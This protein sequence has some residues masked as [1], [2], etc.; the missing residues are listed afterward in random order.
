MLTVI[1]R[2]KTYLDREEDFDPERDRLLRRK[3]NKS[4]D[5]DFF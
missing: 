4:A 1:F 2:F 5:Q 3:K